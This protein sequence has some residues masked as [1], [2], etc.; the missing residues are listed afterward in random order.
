MEEE[1]EDKIP[2]K[3]RAKTPALELVFAVIGLILVGGTI[4]YLLFDA[5]T[6]KDTPPQ[7]IAVVKEIAAQ[8]NGFLVKFEIENKGD[9]HASEVQVEGKLMQGETEKETSSVNIGYAPSHSKRAGGLFFTANPNDFEIKLR[10]LGYA[11]P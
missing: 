5:V 3:S 4:G 11:E 9:N 10:V 8:P 6:E 2:E 1:K 7:I